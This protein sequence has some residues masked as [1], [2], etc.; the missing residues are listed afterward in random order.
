MNQM[1][2]VSYLV[3]PL[4]FFGGNIA[5]DFSKNSK[6]NNNNLIYAEVTHVLQ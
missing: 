6:N 2:G 5:K 3:Y 4:L 1:Q